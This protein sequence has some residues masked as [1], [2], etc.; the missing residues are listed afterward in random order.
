MGPDLMH[1]HSF[2]YTS[3]S[4]AFSRLAVI[5][6]ARILAAKT[7]GI[8][9]A[10]SELFK[11]ARIKIV[12]QGDA[13]AWREPGSGVL[14]GGDHRAGVEIAPLLAVFGNYGRND[15]GFI[16]KPFAMS[17]RLIRGASDDSAM[18][19]PV[20]PGTLAKDRRPIWNRDLGWR[21][22]QGNRL[23]DKQETK[24]LN[25]RTIRRSAELVVGGSLVTIFPGGGIGKAQVKCWRP[26][27]GRILAQVPVR[28]R[29][30]VTVVLFRFEKL[31]AVKLIK[32]LLFQSYGWRPEPQTIQLRVSDPILLADL[33]ADQTAVNCS[34][35]TDVLYRRFID[36]FGRAWTSSKS[37]PRS[38]S[39]S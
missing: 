36:D 37:T 9:Y 34:A 11:L 26:G 29:A 13:A 17:A 35:T 2:D 31:S 12:V 14:F 23:P 1:A 33:L 7:G 8:T 20:F 10:M 19:L 39:A 21:I 15:V 18:L 6:Q 4:P 38:F 32:A 22:S 3:V 24:A 5:R 25:A 27:I 28:S 30:N 16:A